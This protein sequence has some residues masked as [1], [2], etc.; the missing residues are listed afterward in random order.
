MKATLHLCLVSETFPPEINGV[1]NTLG[2][3][4]RGLA[5]RGHQVL[6]V[7]PRQVGEGE[8]QPGI[9]RQILVA[10]WPLPGYPGLQWGRSALHKLLRHWKRQR[11]DVVYIATEGPLGLSALRAARRLAIPVV[12]GFHTNFQLYGEHYGLGLLTR[13]VTGYLRWF[14]N[15]SLLTLVPSQSQRVEL[16]R[17][18]FERLSLLSRG[19]DA[20]LFHPARRCRELRREWGLEEQD[21]AVLHVGR[22]ATEKNLQLLVNTFNALHR[23]YPDKHLRLIIVGDGPQEPA[24][25]QQLPDA[26]FCGLQRGE[27]LARHYACG[28]LFVFPS[29]SETF[30]NVVLEALASGLAVVAFDQAAAAQH[31]RHGHNGALA[32]PG[33]ETAFIEAACALLEDDERLRSLR[34]NARWHASKQGWSSI[35]DGFEQHLRHASNDPQRQPPEL[36]QRSPS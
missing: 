26:R 11:P 34:L 3:L 5:A 12:S 22:L 7:R 20:D 4:S 27:S 24:L 21:I 33:D 18:G 25:R 9:H 8:P 13:A 1:A 19:V 29:L 15:R 30:G 16:Q 17:R 32:M 23:Q 2:Y 36:A 10:G 35:I 14:H 28:D 6:L 31:I